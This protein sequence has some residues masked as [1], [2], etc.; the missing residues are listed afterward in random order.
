MSMQN[1]L[2][3]IQDQYNRGEL[4]MDEANVKLVLTKRVYV[5]TKTP[6]QI[7][8]ALNAAVKVGTLCHMKKDMLLPEVYY[9]PQF[10]YLAKERRAEIVNMKIESLKKVCI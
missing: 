8:K 6:A 5:V 3:M 4:T 10:E 7:R 2:G 1:E 9:H